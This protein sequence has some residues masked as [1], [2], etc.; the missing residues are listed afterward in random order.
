MM[1]RFIE[2]A[3]QIDHPALRA[4]KSEGRPVVGYTCSFVP[5]ELFHAADILGIRLR[6]IETDG[7]EIGDAYFGPYICSF[8]KCVLQLAGRGR[9]A[10]LDG[11]VITPGCDSMRRLYECWQK[12]GEDYPGIVPSFFH[13][14]DV[15]HKTVSHR[16]DWFVEQLNALRTALEER[17]DV[18]ISDD[19]L[20]DAIDLFNT[21]TRLI[22]E[23]E[24]LRKLPF[25]VIS[26]KDAFAI[27]VAGTVMPRDAFNRELE[28]LLHHLKQ[29]KTG[30]ADSRKRLML[31]GS[32]N[33]DIELVNLMESSQQAVVVAD[34][35]CFGSRSHQREISPGEA[36]ME[37]LARSYLE[38]S[39][40]P[41]MF[42]KYRERLEAL[43]DKVD[44]YRVDG[45][46]LQNIRFCD[47]HGSE[48]GLFERDLEKQGIP[49]LKLEREY[50]PLTETGRIRMRIDAFLEGLA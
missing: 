39:T 6:G 41:R 5:T 27:H 37:S 26:G 38:T 42:G 4:W 48:N 25:P 2:A 50:G 18:I 35:L 32:I 17:Y 31:I 40:C 34:N 28:N 43:L 7:L 22:D 11:V 19:K 20:K 49:C 36:P 9:Y 23:L 24:N 14:L 1:T 16:I 45:V 21:G 12:A 29:Q 47:L 15:P 46:V 30:E 13:Y 10:M 44:A 3:T 33:D 8:P